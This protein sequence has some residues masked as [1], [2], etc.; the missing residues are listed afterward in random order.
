MNKKTN[1][2]IL[3]LIAIGLV[4]G[5][6]LTFTPNLG[7]GGAASQQQGDLVMRVNGEGITDLQINQFRNANPIYYAVTEGEVGADLQLLALDAVITQELLRQAAAPMRVSNGEVRD[8][9]NAFRDDRGVAGNDNAYI[10]LLQSAGFDDATF[11]NYMRDQLRQ[12]KWQASVVGEVDVTDEEVRTFFEVFRD[13]Y[14]TDER[15]V[16]RVIAVADEELANELRTR[17]LT[18]ESFAELASAHSVERADRAGALGAAAGSTEP[19]PVGR[20]ALPIAVSNTAFDL[21]AAGLTNVI[22]SGSMYWIVQVEEYLAPTE[23]PFEEVAEQV[24]EDALASREA[25]LVTV[26][27]ERLLDEASIEMVDTSEFNYNNY[28]VATVGDEE[29][30]AADL[31]R[32]TYGNAN[33][34]QF[35]DPSLSFLITEMLKPQI[36][37]QLINQTV[38]F[39]GAADLDANF[40]GT[41]AQIAEYALN[42][43]AR[44]V[45]VGEDVIEAYYNDNQQAYTQNAE[46]QAVSFEFDSFEAAEAFRDDVLSG[47]APT[48]AATSAGIVP[49]DLGVLREGQAETAIDAALFNTDAFAPIDTVSSREIS[50]VLFIAAPVEESGTETDTEASEEADGEAGLPDTTLTGENVAD[51]AEEVD[52]ATATEVAE[53]AADA[54]A[55]VVNGEDE[56]ADL[57]GEAVDDVLEPELAEVE[58]AR[59][60]Y[61]VL[62]AV[63]TEERIRPLEEVRDLVEDAALATARQDVQQAWLEEVRAGLDIEN[64]TAV[65]PDPLGGIDFSPELDFD[66]EDI[67]GIDGDAQAEIEDA[68]SGD[69]DEADEPAAEE[70]AAGDDETE[71]DTE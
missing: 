49:V 48:D 45:T 4:L 25:G 58:A 17:V 31:A 10:Q 41:K 68:V 60:R 55:G 23:R 52:S 18:G 61:V 39:K 2:V 16:A 24:R 9:V 46:A 6:I 64:L 38:A 42:Y 5:M 47:T 66:P 43:V 14:R 51:E 63:R 27:L 67:V 35:L 44:D 1:T 50:D 26:E 36:L 22:S 32:A 15:I 54:A 8:A 71:T 37:D 28:L 33:V 34:Q 19:Q 11:R 53:A 12:Q 56:A 62:V 57:V 7:F 29:L 21:R 69:A 20:A 30:H 3:W 59:D 40:F 65:E 70:D 13:N